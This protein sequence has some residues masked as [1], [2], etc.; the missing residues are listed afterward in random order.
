MPAN[1]MTPTI[2][3]EEAKK[4]LEPLGVTVNIY[5]SKWIENEKMGSFLAVAQGSV[6]PPVFLEMIYNGCGGEKPPI[7]FVG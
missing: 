7:V 5:D 4:A 2:V 3:G 6:Q 1:L